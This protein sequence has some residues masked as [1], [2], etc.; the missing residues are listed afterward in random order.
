[1]ECK[2]LNLHR[3]LI[4]IMHF[5]YT[6]IMKYF[7]IISNL[8]YQLIIKLLIKNIIKL[9]KNNLQIHIYLENNQYDILH[10]I[11][12]INHLLGLCFKIIILFFFNLY[13]FLKYIIYFLKDYFNE[14]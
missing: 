2:Q 6:K 10:I 7:N 1:M 5:K 9:F 3:I 12:L 13:L 14:K 4:I 8:S 11:K